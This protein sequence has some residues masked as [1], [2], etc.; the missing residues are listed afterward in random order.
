MR[1]TT[2]IYGGLYYS[3]KIPNNIRPTSDKT[4][5][6]IFNVLSNLVDFDNCIC[7]DLCSGTGA[8]GFESLSRGVSHVTLV[9]NS[10]KSCELASE[11]AKLFKIPKED[12]S[13]I[14][15]DA[16]KFV[17]DY[18]DESPKIDLIFCDPPYKVD[19]I[20][21]LLALLTEKDILNDSAII[22][23]EYPKDMKL[24]IPTVFRSISHKTF[25]ETQVEFIEIV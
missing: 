16:L 11:I 3:G 9:D 1:L 2:G 15:R 7:L 25:G 5:Q 21:P 22:T 4:R 23:L 8:L 13:I 14:C 10:K 20:N 19:V 17:R 12:Y 18:S 24:H 6:S